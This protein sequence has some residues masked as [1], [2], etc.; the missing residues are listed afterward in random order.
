MIPIGAWRGDPHRQLPRCCRLLG[1]V[2]TV[3]GLYVCT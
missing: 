3:Y 1:V 2:M